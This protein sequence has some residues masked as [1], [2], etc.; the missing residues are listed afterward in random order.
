MHYAIILIVI[1]KKKTYSVNVVLFQ[2]KITVLRE[3]YFCFTNIM[4]RMRLE[5]FEIK[6]KITLSCNHKRINKVDSTKYV[7]YRSI[8]DLQSHL[9]NITIIHEKHN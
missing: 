6:S 9:H 8:H 2:K 4:I 1:S 7:T 5:S 3:V